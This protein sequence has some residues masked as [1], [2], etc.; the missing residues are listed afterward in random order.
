MSK[1]QIVSSNQ[2]VEAQV[3]SSNQEAEDQKVEA[4]KVEV[5]ETNQEVKAHE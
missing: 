1:A 4:Q 2:K 5:I 3:V